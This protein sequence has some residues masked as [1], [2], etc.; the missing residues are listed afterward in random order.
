MP[1]LKTRPLSEQIIV[2]TGASS[3]IG[4]ATA[5]MAAKKGARVILSSRHADALNKIVK[6]LQADGGMAHAIPADVRNEVDMIRLRDEVLALYFRIDTWVNNAGASIYGDILEIP[7]EE[8]K[9]LFETNFW[10]VRH[11]CRAAVPALF[12]EGG[13]LINVG[14][15][16]SQRAIPLQGMYSATKHAV[17]AYTDALRIELEKKKSPIAVCLIR[18]AGIDTPF[19]DHA[20]NHLKEGEPSLPPPVYHPDVVAK[21]ILDC[22]VTP[23]RDVFIGGASKFFA[24]LD[25]VLPGIAD[26]VIESTLFKS[27]SKGTPQAHTLENEGL[28]RAPLDQGKVEGSY[29]GHVMKSSL[30]TSLSKYPVLSGLLIGGAA[31]GAAALALGNTKKGGKRSRNTHNQLH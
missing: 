15:E 10:G 9:Q 23:K 3:G 19:T 12:K 6:E 18:P 29:P 27:Q 20:R 2:I 22:A 31:A 16:V 8:E 28:L 21:A 4:L 1:E 25:T 30:Y 14:S 17:K 5:K 24:L 13:V 11:G 7:L 26:K